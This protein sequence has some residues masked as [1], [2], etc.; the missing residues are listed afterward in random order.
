MDGDIVFDA[1]EQ[2][3]KVRLVMWLAVACAFG[4]G[5]WGWSL[6]QTYG[7]APGDG[8]VLA[9]VGVRLAVGGTVAVLGLLAAAAMGVYSRQYIAQIRRDP[10]GDRLI[11]ATPRLIGL[12]E[13]RYAASAVRAGE[14]RDTRA[15]ANAFGT[16]IAVHAPWRVVHVAGR[17]L[18][19]ILDEQGRWPGRTRLGK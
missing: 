10:G 12:R 2:L 7:L 15:V 9:P 8:G 11:I 17:R 16:G 1:S 18:P 13:S 14:A 6:S 19:L 5:Y 4:G 3:T